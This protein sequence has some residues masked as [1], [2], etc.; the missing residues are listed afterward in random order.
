MLDLDDVIQRVACDV[1]RKLAES[2]S[3]DEQHI[4]DYIGHML[5]AHLSLKAAKGEALI[6]RGVAQ[7]SV[8]RRLADVLDVERED[9][10]RIAA[11]MVDAA[12]LIAKGD[13]WR[14]ALKL[15]L[16]VEAGIARYIDVVL[17]R[18][19][20]QSWVVARHDCAMVAVNTQDGNAFEVFYLYEKPRDWYALR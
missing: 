20:N 11:L 19:P 10:N 1:A 9:A 5:E 3:M 7:N 15:S 2:P 6:S 4:A 12:T 13:K 8:A 18:G 17:E 14:A 16:S